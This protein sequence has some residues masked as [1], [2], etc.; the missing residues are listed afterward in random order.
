MKDDIISIQLKNKDQIRIFVIGKA[1]VDQFP[2]ESR[3]RNTSFNFVSRICMI[4]G[5]IPK[6][7]YLY[8]F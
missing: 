8:N 4:L 5:V 6:D 2:M 3:P 1:L 7:E